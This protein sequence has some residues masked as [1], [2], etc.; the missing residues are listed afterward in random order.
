MTTQRLL[1]LLLLCLLLFA[2]ND[3]N[4]TPP[5]DPTP[6]DGEDTLSWTPRARAPLPLFEAQ[7]GVVNGKLY[8]FGGYDNEAI[9][10]T[11]KSSVYDP[12]TDSW[13]A[14]TPVPEAITHAGNA[15][16]GNTFYLAGGFLG[17][18]PGPSTD[19]VWKYDTLTNTWSEGPP[20]PAKRGGGALVTLG[21]ELHFFGGTVREEGEYLEDSGDH[22][23]LD[24]DNPT[25][26][27]TAPPMPNPRNHIT[28]VA[29]NGKAYAI[30]GQHLG[31]EEEGNQRSVQAFDPA[32]GQWTE[33]APLPL[34]LS[35]TESSSFVRGGRI[36]VIG[37][38]TQESEEVA[39]VLEYDPAADSWRKLTPLPEVR[40][41]PI[42]GAVG[43]DI[44][45]STGS[46]PGGVPEAD[47]WLGR[48]VT[49]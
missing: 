31:D 13:S 25:S 28:G 5:V 12:A 14:L 49:R 23:V 10:A 27:E 38:V 47:T 44:V 16:D 29:L 19:H 20:L 48:P 8:V 32:T 6:P 36:V 7:G 26:W 37:G 22:W 15:V 43:E 41:S 2:C 11:A 45:V 33:A 42:A 24:L 34:P 4:P 30:G 35:H 9:E 21:R 46:S 17:D 40:Q 3:A 18:H 39:S 1:P